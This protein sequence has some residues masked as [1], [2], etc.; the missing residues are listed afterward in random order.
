MRQ[1][2][3]PAEAPLW[4]RPVLDSIR[5]ALCDRFDGPI[6]LCSST[7][8]GLPSAATAGAGATLYVSDETGGAVIAYS[9]G[10]DWRRVTDRAVVS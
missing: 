6:R 5:S 4:L 1:F 2:F 10:T 8:A 7:V 3:R 9:D